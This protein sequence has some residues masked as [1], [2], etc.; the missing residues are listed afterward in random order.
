[1]RD[2]LRSGN[3]TP[4]RIYAGAGEVGAAFELGRLLGTRRG[5][6]TI[7]RSIA[8]TWQDILN[9]NVVFLGSPK[10]N[11]QTKDI[12]VTLDLVMNHD[13]IQNLRPRPGE[14]MVLQ[15]SWPSK[16]PYVVEDYALI[17]RLPGLQGRGE[18]LIVA[19]YSTE[20]TDAAVQYVT[21]ADFARELVRRL[22]LPS[23]E[24]PEYFQVV[25]KA[26]FKEMVPVELAYQFHHVL[27]SAVKKSR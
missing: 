17:S 4:V 8:T 2:D 20:G 19:A 10:V 15:G 6:L 24:L 9:H 23:G 12:P 1:M 5:D 22:R 26:R 21:K 25:V 18:I 11:L 14:P 13:S 27:T 3:A 16:S 7:K